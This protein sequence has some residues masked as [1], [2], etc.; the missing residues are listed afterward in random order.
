MKIGF[1]KHHL[2]LAGTLA[3]FALLVSPLAAQASLDCLFYT[4][5]ER[6]ICELENEIE[7]ALDHGNVRKADK[8]QAEL[9][10]FR[11]R[12]SGGTDRAA[13][14]HELLSLDAK[15]REYE[16][17]VAAITEDVQQET[18]KAATLAEYRLK[19]QKALGELAEGLDEA[20][21]DVADAG[22]DLK[23]EVEEFFDETVDVG[24]VRP[25]SA[26]EARALI[27]EIDRAENGLEV[28]EQAIR[29]DLDG[30]LSKVQG[31]SGLAD[32]EAD[33]RD[34]IAE[35]AGQYARQRAMLEEVRRAVQGFLDKAS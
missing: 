35:I 16:K 7:S 26:L 12:C 5:C 22:D 27:R 25:G 18:Q 2:A 28:S 30:F 3:A 9:D 32:R 33:Y 24:S 17:K 29:E 13:L 23:E 1:G 14:D 6:K 21:D 4:G 10:A 20:V 8:L 15:I 34:G 31:V 19:T 11:L